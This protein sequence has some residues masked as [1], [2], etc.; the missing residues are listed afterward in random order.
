MNIENRPAQASVF[1]AL[2]LAAA[3]FMIYLGTMA[4]AYYVTAISLFIGAFCLWTAWRPGLFKAILVLNQITATTLIV[5]IVY[6]KLALPTE[7]LTLSISGLALI[8][9]IFVG[10]P[11]LSILSIP[12]LGLLSYRKALHEWLD[13]SSKQRG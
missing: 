12:V 1:S 3:L 4:S 7:E 6:R 2:F 8:G 9:N 13:K 10:G 5:I 11:L